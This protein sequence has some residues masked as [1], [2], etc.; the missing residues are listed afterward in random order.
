LL[1]SISF[2]EVSIKGGNRRLFENLLVRNALAS[3]A[4]F[5]SFRVQ[6]R[7]GRILLSSDKGPDAD[8]VKGALTKTFGIDNITLSIEAKPDMGDIEKTVLAN[9]SD[10]INHS[11]KVEAKRSDKRFPLT[12]QQ[13]N[14]QVGAALVKAGCT[15]DLENPERTIFIDVLDKEALVSFERIK[16]PGGLPVGSSGKM[17]SL[18]SGGID[19]PV[20]SWMMMKRGCEVDFLHLHQF[21]DNKDVGKSK[22]M[23]ILRTLREYSPK[24]L[25]LFVVPYTEFYK[26]SLSMDQR[27]ELVV[28]RRFIIHLANRFAR[29]EGY[30][31]IITGDSIGQVASQTAENLLATD[32]AS[33]LPVY[34]PLIGF[35]KQEIVDLARKIGTYEASIEEY[36]DCCSLVAN[37][38]PC[39]KVPLDVAKKMED[40]IKISEVVEKSLKQMEIMD[41]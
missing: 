41:V 26:K 7:G 18:L 12:S 29:E 38:S 25:R 10:L 8:A 39:T 36:K 22:M 31:G 30:K 9:S 27:N 5:G 11:I 15:V 3:L 19:S 33:Q 14:A 37:K 16:G 6:K 17:I 40:E 4:P 24:K 21:P 2:S 1:I 34:R 13:I 20:S 23:R 28:F 35:N 32:E